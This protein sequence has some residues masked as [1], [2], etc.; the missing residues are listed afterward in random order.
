[1]VAGAAS[2]GQVNLADIDVLERTLQLPKGAYPLNDYARYYTAET[3]SHRA[4][5]RGYFLWHGPE[6]AGRY[7]RA[8]SVTVADGGCSV[9]TVYFDVET[10]HVAGAY[11][12]GLA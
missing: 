9:V 10:R 7:L 11:C 1:V 8:S 12:N 5:V 4:M 2:D 3:V 6:A